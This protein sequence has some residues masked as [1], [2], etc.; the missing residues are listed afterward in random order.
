MVKLS[1]NEEFDLEQK[2]LNQLI[3]ENNNRNTSLSFDVQLGIIATNIDGEESI[4]VPAPAPL[5]KTDVF[6]LTEMSGSIAVF[7]TKNYA[8]SAKDGWEVQNIYIQRAG[9]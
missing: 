2:W 7:S 8:P 1:A 6:C 9:Y 3:A 5:Q 4:L